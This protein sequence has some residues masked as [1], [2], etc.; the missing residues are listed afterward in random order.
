MEVVLLFFG[1][2][3]KARANWEGILYAVVTIFLLERVRARWN[4]IEADGRRRSLTRER[5]ARDQ[6]RLA[7][8][9]AFLYAIPLLLPVVKY[10][11]RSIEELSWTVQ[12]LAIMKNT[13]V[14]FVVLVLTECFLAFVIF[15]LLRIYVDRMNAALGF[16]QKIGRNIWDGSKVAVQVSGDMSSRVVGGVRRLSLGTVSRAARATGKARV[17]ASKLLSRLYPRK[18]RSLG[19][20]VGVE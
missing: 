18:R 6:K 9:A 20:A 15:N 4:R 7:L 14:F 11:Y 10:I 5:I 19:G 3:N 1:V 16:F 8:K 17:R 2:W 13:W 12:G